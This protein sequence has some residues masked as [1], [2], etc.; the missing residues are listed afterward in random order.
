M[1]TKRASKGTRPGGG[2]KGTKT[3]GGKKGTRPGGGGKGGT[4]RPGGGGGKGGGKKGPT[5]T[6]GP[7]LT[8]AAAHDLHRLFQKCVDKCFA[9]FLTCLKRE[10]DSSVCISQVR[11]CIGK[12]AAW[13]F[14]KPRVPGK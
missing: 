13:V 4:K 10:D 14:A 5:G 7:K 9:D 1:A 8:P 6:K 12:C 2:K 3:G 11:A